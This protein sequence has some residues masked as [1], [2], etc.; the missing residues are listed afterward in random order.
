MWLDVAT[1]PSNDPW[2][3]QPLHVLA[4]VLITIHHV[5]KQTAADRWLSHR[6]NTLNK[7]ELWSHWRKHRLMPNPITTTPNSPYEALMILY[8]NHHKAENVAKCLLQIN[9][10]IIAIVLIKIWDRIPETIL[11]LSCEFTLIQLTN[12]HFSVVAPAQ[13]LW[14][15]QSIQLLSLVVE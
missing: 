12:S 14:C 8:S 4:T 1:T 7:H 6:P 2:L 5:V 3:P 13:G 11:I 15:D 9:L 10:L